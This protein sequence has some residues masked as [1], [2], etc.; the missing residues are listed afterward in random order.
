MAFTKADLNYVARLARLSLTSDEAEKLSED[1]A[2]IVR[3]VEQLQE[4]NIDGVAPMAHAGDRVLP[5]RE[6]EAKHVLGRECIK[7][8]AGFEDGLIRVPKIIE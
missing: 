5:F 8:S 3:F 1:L 6:D 7:S 4:V 2:R